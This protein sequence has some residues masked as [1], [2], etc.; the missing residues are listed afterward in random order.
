MTQP[1]NY[2]A[3]SRE[4]IAKAHEELA[5]GDIRKA[6][7]KGWGAAAQ[8]VKAVAERRGWPHNGH[9]YLYQVVRRLVEETG[10]HELD[11]YF[12]VAGNLHS[13]FYEDWLP[14]GSVESGLLSVRRLIEKLEPMLT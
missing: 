13:N 10:D 12:H 6:S 4:L 3:A 1:E 14:S 8:M 11:T 7:E 2:S 9:S 5:Q